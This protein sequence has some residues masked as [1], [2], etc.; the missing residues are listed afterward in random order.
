MLLLARLESYQSNWEHVRDVTSSFR[1]R[2]PDHPL[3]IEARYWLAESSFRLGAVSDAESLYVELSRDACTSQESWAAMVPLRLA[4]VAASR[5]DWQAALE[6]AKT[7]RAVHPGFERQFEA[8]YLMGRCH[9]SLG[10]FSAAREAYQRV[11]QSVT[12]GRYRDR[13]D[14]T[15]DDRRDLHAPG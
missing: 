6:Q 11:L 8:D 9:A 2:F 7:I 12:A 13:R 5:G 10:E 1:H 15:V 14:G 3:A 4:Q